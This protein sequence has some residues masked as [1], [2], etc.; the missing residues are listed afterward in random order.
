MMYE[1]SVGAGRSQ[2]LKWLSRRESIFGPFGRA[3]RGAKAR[4]AKEPCQRDPYLCLDYSFVAHIL[5]QT[6]YKLIV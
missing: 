6:E 3:S 4:A 2:V 5:E 1:K